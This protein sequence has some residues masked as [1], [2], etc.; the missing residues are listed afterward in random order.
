MSGVINIINHSIAFWH[1]CL[2]N[3]DTCTSEHHG[4]DACGM[5]TNNK[6]HRQSV[7]KV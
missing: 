5:I 6:Q 2:V 7:Y 1:L 3:I 4:G